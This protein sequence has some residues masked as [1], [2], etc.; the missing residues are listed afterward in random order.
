MK[1]ACCPECGKKLPEGK[2]FCNW[3]SPELES[4]GKHE[5]ACQD[6]GSNLRDEISSAGCDHSVVNNRSSD[7]E[8]AG[9]SQSI[10]I[11]FVIFVLLFMASPL[12]VSQLGTTLNGLLNSNTF[13]DWIP[14]AWAVFFTVPIGGIVLVVTL[15][16]RLMSRNFSSKVEK[17]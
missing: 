2:P 12:I 8:Q 17:D 14:F 9:N 4:G 3:C 7:E 13:S 1:T 16:L 15:I 5:C 6:C 11:G 10:L